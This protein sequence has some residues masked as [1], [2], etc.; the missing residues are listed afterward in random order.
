VI[1]GGRGLGFALKAG[2]GL[3]IARYILR[4][5][6]EGDE[7]VKARILG[8]VDDAHAATTELLDDAVVRD[9]LADHC[10]ETALGEAC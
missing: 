6:F 9:N 4:K 2:E 3:R 7:T 1:K 8:F 10:L 5:E